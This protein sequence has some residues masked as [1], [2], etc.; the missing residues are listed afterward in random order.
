MP[1]KYTRIRLAAGF[2]QDPL[3]ELMRSPR[4]PSRNRGLLLRGEEMGGRGGRPTYKEKEGERP[5]SKEEGRVKMKERGGRKWREREFPLPT[6]QKSR[7]SIGSGRPV[8]MY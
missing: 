8:G 2:R 7:I 3:G 5:T 6:S 4:S 1:K